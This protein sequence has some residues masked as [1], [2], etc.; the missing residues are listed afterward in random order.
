MISVSGLCV[1]FSGSY[2]FEEVSFL[3]NK[4]DKIGLAGKNGAGKSTLLKVLKGLQRPDEGEVSMPK[5]ATVGYLA[6]DLKADSTKTVIEETRSAFE[7]AVKIEEELHQIQAE[8]AERT[9]YES[10]S[11]LKLLE[12]LHD[13]EHRFQILGGYEIEE[14]TEKI[15]KGL[16]FNETDFQKK[17]SEFSGGWQMRVE[18]AK[19]L[20]QQPDLIILDEPTNHLDIE[21]I[22]WLEG[23]L[24]EYPKAVMLVSHDKSFLDKVTN[25]TIEISNGSIQDYRAPYSKYLELR[26]ERRQQLMNAHKNQQ[27]QISQMERNIDRF[28]A[29]ASKAS[30]AQSLIKKLDK[31]ERIEVE[32][33]DTAAIYFRFPKAPHS[34]KMVLNADKISKSYGPKK[35]IDDIHLQVNRGDRIAFVGKNGMGKTTLSRIIIG[36]LEYEGHVEKGHNVL[37]GYYAQHQ[38]GTLN[39]EYT[40][41]EE[42][43]KA[44]YTSDSFT[45]VRSILG[46]FLFSGDDVYK[47][48]KVLSGGEKSRLALAKMLLQPLNLLVLDEPTNHLDIRSKEVLKNALL[49]FEGTIIV[50]SHDRDF[51]AG[52][53]DKVFEFADGKLKEHLGGITEFLEKKNAASFRDIEGTNKN[54]KAAKSSQSEPVETN[55]KE[56]DKKELE[57]QIKKLKN[58]I[59]QIESTIESIEIKISDYD[60]KLQDPNEY[61]HYTGDAAFF[62][63]YNQLK[64][65]LERENNNW[66][67]TIDELSKLEKQLR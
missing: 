7:E 54:T 30:M 4:N 64:K 33:E 19:I 29:K 28:R 12:K 1:G 67:E 63:K 22:I 41:L 32:E 27:S 17:L 24:Y 2:L 10:D 15:L 62:T 39:P 36:D 44:A 59:N 52:L 53:V 14:K 9:D 40:V 13:K 34:G 11:Y 26:A 20:L 37:L 45:Q 47:K 56:G 23:F 48:T 8:V 43:E 5:D 50:V 61:K 35:V 65:D 16:G 60:Q 46:A 31:I 58:R 55:S 51:L 21:S 25:R 42:M 49:N 6:Q 66:S 3:I 57:K 18:L 38:T